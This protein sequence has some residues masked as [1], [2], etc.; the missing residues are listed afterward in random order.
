M[1]LINTD[2]MA[3]IGPG[4]EWFW[5]AVSGLVLAVTFIAIYRQLRLQRS[6]NSYG[7]LT[8]IDRQDISEPM[9]RMKLQILEALRDGVEPAQVPYGAASYVSDFWE[10]TAALVRLGHIDV[11]LLHLVM[12]NGCRRW[13][14]M[15]R[16]F[17]ERARVEG[18]SRASPRSSSGSPGGWPSSTGGRATRSRTSSR[19]SAKDSTSTSR[20]TQTASAL[21]RSSAPSSSGRCHRRRLPRAWSRR[22]EDV[23][24]V[25]VHRRAARS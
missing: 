23:G 25:A 12:G 6:A 13:W 3:F 18:G 9:L 17:L 10:S 11:R 19:R 8:E 1:K 15:L 7:Q 2:G 16:P 20:T 22:S 24:E 21:R 14:A 4:S 5:T